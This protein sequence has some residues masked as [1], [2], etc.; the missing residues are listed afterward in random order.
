MKRIVLCLAVIALYLAAAVFGEVQCRRARAAD[1][2]PAYNVVDSA[3]RNRPPLTRI[4][5]HES[6]GVRLPARR[7]WLG[8]DSL[9]RDVLLRVVQGA[10]I[11]FHVGI[12]TSLVA[13]PLGA[14]L[15]LLAGWRGRAVDAFLCM[16]AA[17]FASIPSVLLV[18]AMAMVVGRGLL[19]IYIGISLATWVGVFRNVRAE[20]MRQR[21][22][23]YVLSARALGY[24]GGRILF[25]HILPNVAHV[26]LVTFS[27]RFP[28][29]V[30]TEVF[31]SFLGIGVRDDPSWGVMI[32]NARVRLWQGVWWEGA[33]VTIAIFGLVLSFNLLG[34]LIRDRLDPRA[35]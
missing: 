26:I 20:T 19:G 10:R 7:A 3:Y 31:L 16:L 6:G 27:L 13:V 33:A 35:G 22:L 5:A 30:G 28:A 29:A 34:D 23:G 8:T 17:V 15:G 21:D 18:L 25:R 11:A 1:V 24:G 12:V 14:L 4:P 32:N 2:T 9:G